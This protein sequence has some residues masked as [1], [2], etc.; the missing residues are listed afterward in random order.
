MGQRGRQLF[1]IQFIIQK[2][3]L[4]SLPE[5][6]R[7]KRCFYSLILF[8]FCS[9]HSRACCIANQRT[10]FPRRD[11]D[12]GSRKFLVMPVE[13]T[14]SWHSL[15]WTVRIALAYRQKEK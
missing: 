8:V 1:L 4:K 2:R 12:Y 6:K 7:R 10:V 5:V 15:L 9:K 13:F 14:D 3:W 11:Y